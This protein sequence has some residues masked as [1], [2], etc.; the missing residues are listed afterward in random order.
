MNLILKHY[1]CFN[2]YQKCVVV[3]ELQQQVLRLHMKIRECG[4]ISFVVLPCLLRTFNFKLQTK[5]CFGYNTSKQKVKTHFF[6]FEMQDTDRRLKALYFYQLQIRL[7]A[8][9]F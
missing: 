4:M 2:L 1:H 7:F 8:Y 9:I 6:N 3:M 5:R